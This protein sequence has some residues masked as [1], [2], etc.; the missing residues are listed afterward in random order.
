MYVCVCICVRIYVCIFV[1]IYMYVY[2]HLG[3]YEEHFLT[4][5][6]AMNTTVC[7]DL[8]KCYFLP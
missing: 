1:C 7:R 5:K 8:H 4:P 3:F 2:V 6:S